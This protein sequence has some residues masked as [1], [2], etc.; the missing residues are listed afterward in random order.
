MDG[1]IADHL[2]AVKTKVT[3]VKTLSLPR[4]E[5]SGATIGVKLLQS[6]NAALKAISMAKLDCFGWTNSTIV[7]QWLTHLTR[8]WTT[9]V[10]NR[11]SQIQGT[12]PREN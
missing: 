8:K 12:M 1:D 6:I 3:P 10:A 7:L 9:F 5:L 2:I 4:L 11:V